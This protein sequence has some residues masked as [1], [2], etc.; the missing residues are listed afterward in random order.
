MKNKLLG[1]I[2][3]LPKETRINRLISLLNKIPTYFIYNYSWIPK[4]IFKLCE[5]FGYKQYD[6]IDSYRKNN[7][8]FV[9]NNYLKQPSVSLLKSLYENRDNYKLIELT[10]IKKYRLFYFG[11]GEKFISKFFPWIDYNDKN[12][13]IITL[14]NTIFIPDIYISKFIT[15]LNNMKI[16]YYKNPT[17]KVVNNNSDNLS[18][19]FNKFLDN[20][21]YLPCL[22]NMDNS[23]IKELQTIL[24]SIFPT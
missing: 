11:F 8:G 2:N 23:E 24:L 16:P 7:P 13:E 22:Y 3:K 12:I 4:Y 5:Y 20:L 9:H 17:W 6:I 19:K 14:Y 15:I 1:E 18:Y 10:L 21:Y